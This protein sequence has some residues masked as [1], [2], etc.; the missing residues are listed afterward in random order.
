MK[1]FK[2]EL[3]DTAVKRIGMSPEALLDTLA[4]TAVGPKGER[5]EFRYTAKM[6]SEAIMTFLSKVSDPQAVSDALDMFRRNGAD[7][8]GAAQH[9][10]QSVVAR[11]EQ[12][13]AILRREAPP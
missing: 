5:D 2:Q 4:T 3:I 13:L 12:Q 6:A 10:Y 7:A 9:L 11:L 1:P 8:F